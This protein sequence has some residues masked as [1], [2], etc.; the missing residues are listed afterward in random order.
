M[1]S[2]LLVKPFRINISSLEMFLQGSLKKI[3]RK[4]KINPVKLFIT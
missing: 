4:L 3:Q 2:F 1:L